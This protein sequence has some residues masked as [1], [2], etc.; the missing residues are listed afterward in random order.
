[1][2]DVF[3]I[4]GVVLD[5]GQLENY[6]EKLA[7]DNV[8]KSNSSKETYPV[9]TLI[10]NFEFITK[11]YNLLGE[12]LKL[13]IN[14]HP[15][16][17]WL[18]DNY[19]II[20]ETVKQ[21]TQ[22]LTKKK[23]TNFVGLA[24]GSYKGMA[25]IYFLAVHMCA[26]T[27]NHIEKN[28]LLYMLRAYQNKKSL[29]M[30]EIW[31]IGMFLQIAILENI[32]EVCKKI[33]S[34]QMQKYRVE[35]IVERIIE[36]KSK[37][38]QR[39][40]EDMSYRSAKFG[41]GE[42]K[43][44]FIEYMSYRLK[45][46][47]KKAYGYL[48][49]LEEQV[50]K[51]GTTIS[52]VIKKEHF[53]IAL[54]KITIGNSI[55]S[56]KEINRI[57]FLEIFEKVN[58]VEEVLK[59]DPANVYDKMDYK[60]KEYYRNEIKEVARKTKI[61]EMYIAQKLI[62]LAQ[63]AKE[64]KKRHI[65][66]YLI[67][68]GKT[69]LWKKLG[70]QKKEVEKRK[71][72][73]YYIGAIYSITIVLSFLGA[74]TIGKYHIG[75][76]ILIFLLLII[77]IS[78]IMTQIMQYGMNKIVKPKLIP[79]LDMAKGIDKE[80]ATMVVIPT[81]IKT[82]E[83]V[84]RLFEQLEVYYLANQSDH[85]YFTLLG[86]C[87]AAEREK[88]EYDDEIIEQGLLCARQ[89]NEKYP[90]TTFSRFH[91]L[92]RKRRWNEGESAYLGWERKRGLLNQLNEFLL[93]KEKHDFIV[94]TLEREELPYIKY[95]ITL[96]ADTDLI[97]NS[98]FELIGAMSHILNRPTLDSENNIISGH[99]LIQPKVGIDLLS[100]RKTLFTRIFAGAGGTDLYTN[101]ISDTYQDNFDE[102]IFTGKGIYD[103]STFERVL[104]GQIPE[105]TVLSHD[106]L[107]GSYLRCGLASDILL[108]D[109]YPC[110]YNSFMQRLHRWIRG[111][112]QIT[113]WMFSKI[114]D[115]KGNARKNPL[116]FLS[117][118]KIWDNLRRS[119]V[120][121]SSILTIFVLLI[122]YFFYQT[123]I[124]GP[125]IIAILSPIF[126]MILE[127]INQIIYRKEGETYQK[128][129]SP[130]IQGWKGSCYRAIFNLAFWPDKAYRSVDAIIRTIYRKEVSKK[131][132]LEWTTAEEA[133]KNAKTDYYSYYKNMIINPILGILLLIF[134]MSSKYILIKSIG[135]VLAFLWIAGP[136][137]ACYISKEEKIQAK[138]SVLDDKEQKYVLNI[139]K[140]TWE[141][142]KE[143]LTQENNYLPP[144]NYQ[145]NRKQKLVYRTSSTNIGLALLAV[146][147][148]YD[149]GFENLENSIEL[150]RN[151][152]D[153]IEKLSKWNGHLYNWYEIKTLKPLVPRYIS[154]V[155]SGNFVGYLYVLKQFLIEVKNKIEQQER[156]EQM[157]E[158]VNKLIKQTDFSILYDEEKRIFSIGFN[159]EEN[160]LTESYYDLLASEAR[161]ASLVAISKKDVPVKHW[162]NLSRTLTNLNRYQGL[163]SWSG[164]TFEYLMP[165]INIKTYPGSLMDESCRFLIMSQMAYSNKIGIPWGISE[166][167]FNLKDLNG[168]YQYK[169]FGV[170]WLGLK[171]GLAD[172]AVVSSYGSLLAISYYPKEVVQ[173]IKRMEKEG[174]MG[175]YGMY[176]SIDYTSSRLKYGEKKAVVKTFMAHHQGLILLSINNLFHEQ[177]LQE[178]FF[179]NPEIKA[180]D[181]LL[182]ERMPEKVI[183]TKEKKEKPEKLKYKDYESYSERT[184]T[185]TENWIENVNVISNEDYT[186]VM[187]QKGE[188]YSKYHNLYINRYKET[189]DVDQGIFFY[190]KNINSKR[191]WSI[192]E[193]RYLPSA[194]KYQIHFMPDCDRINRMDGDIETDL[195]VT[196]APN[197]PIEIRTVELTNHGNQEETVEITGYLEPI[198]STK[199]Q[200]CSHM[201]FNNLFLRYEKEEETNSI[202]VERRKRVEGENDIF[203]GVNFYTEEETIGELEYEID[204]EKFYGR[205]NLNLP[206]MIQ[207]SKT[208]SKKIGFVTDPAIAIKRTI[209]I[210]PEESVQLTLILAVSNEKEKVKEIIKEYQNGEKIKKVFE[211]AKVRA[212][213]EARYLGVKGKEIEEAQEILAL[214]LRPNPMKVLETKWDGKR[215]F[216]QSDLWKFRD[217]R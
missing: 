201:A 156:I 131:H 105:N 23:Y 106:L 121:V 14:I 149:L 212:M 160:K 30:E 73:N 71:K 110:K 183:L 5:R 135:I 172:E 120:E 129:F 100:S 10:E 46:L 34:S 82:R 69:E 56:I 32:A 45:R 20:E 93:K 65:G 127:I 102:G 123:P 153:T 205:A 206:Q 85:L 12:H 155:D 66:Y 194:D 55:T 40:S 177:I 132:L 91:F 90:S 108:M 189:A 21:I 26:C 72:V 168:N 98:A 17:E 70:F 18:L 169:A 19:Y 43:Y 87:E 101:A 146:V 122:Y 179:Q 49:A 83:K 118:Y 57:N 79:K 53:D 163:I 24:N 63:E 196:I 2:F 202:M 166:S 198:L 25:R 117:R 27:D 89:L 182:Q 193:M 29:S 44:P 116:N 170:P 38:E 33:Y 165:N 134:T 81:I 114:K 207:N 190:I 22:E 67:S 171:R 188:S 3:N 210:K 76:G 15:A 159:I 124:K 50:K 175:R 28:N 161:Q 78:E 125:F 54:R 68:D 41:F 1:M 112:W 126:P 178:R 154:T 148:S 104:Q 99:A 31:N 37:G 115:D 216:S 174:V 180:I 144:D 181:I 133:E 62:D 103:L 167:A 6:M 92:Y 140:K 197:E 80:N 42:M 11:V 4:R 84:K 97:L 119:L 142:F 113:R 162:N 164:T 51:L 214:L 13:G 186:I 157:I 199:E 211:L 145:E 150:I 128:T 173:N 111:D 158:I 16:G 96:D 176:E 184:Y 75:Y 191:I 48:D 151:M 8:L 59:R 88:K 152:L 192:N 195:K 58:S 109:G 136:T 204:R 147:S 208:L 139:A 74:W 185:K 209:R 95:I 217:I 138:V 77:P 213:E 47:G 64:E 137:I 36:G 9:P 35:G 60:T 52:D 107:E 143:N 130:I 86:D 187:N 215:I 61:S 203:L 7:S 200:D 39:F 141:Y 94:N